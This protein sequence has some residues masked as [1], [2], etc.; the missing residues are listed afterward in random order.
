MAAGLTNMGERREGDKGKKEM[1]ERNKEN[2]S[3]HISDRACASSR[4]IPVTGCE[5]P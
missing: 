4:A 3:R 2:I 5:S 1:R